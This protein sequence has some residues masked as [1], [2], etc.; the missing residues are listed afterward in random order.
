MKKFLTFIWVLL[1]PAII[2]I[3]IIIVPML[4]LLWVCTLFG[5]FVILDPKNFPCPSWVRWV[6][7]IFDS[8]CVILLLYNAISDAYN[9]VYKN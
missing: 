5:L 4:A 9:K 2:N 1:G 8:L 3:S 7:G 6:I